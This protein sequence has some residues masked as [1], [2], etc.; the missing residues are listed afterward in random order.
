MDIG[1]AFSDSWNTYLKNF[2]I[3][4]LAGIVSAIL[5][6]LIAPMVGLQMM[7]VK[8][9]RG[10]AVA[11]GDVFAP[12]SKFLSLVLAILFFGLVMVGFMIPSVI[13]FYFNWPMIGS[14][15]ML[16]AVLAELY[17][18]VCWMFSLMLIYD[19]GLAVMD[20]LKT[21]REIVLKNNWWM[22]LLLVILSGIVGGLGNLLWGIGAFL[23]MP[24]AVGAIASA[25]A[26]EA[27]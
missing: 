20:S 12:F 7:F 15:F 4:F 21:S 9:K 14:I 5:G 24:L 23:T 6:I 27:K 25:Y 1:K 10:G 18:G 22:H 16:L 3:I 11:F 13:C 17:L 2:I 8:A 19:K 26:E